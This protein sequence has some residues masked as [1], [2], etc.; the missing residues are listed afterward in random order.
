MIRDEKCK[1]TSTKIKTSPVPAK[2]YEPASWGVAVVCRTDK[3]GRPWRAFFFNRDGRI[4]MARIVGRKV[5]AGKS[6]WDPDFLRL[7]R[8]GLVFSRRYYDCT[9]IRH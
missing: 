2:C 8:R 9:L 5:R 3:Q 6:G 7:K 4:L 1:T